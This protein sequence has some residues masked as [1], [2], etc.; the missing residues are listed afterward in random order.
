TTVAE[1]ALKRAPSVR[2]GQINEF[3]HPDWVARERL[4]NE[5]AG[6]RPATPLAEGFAKTALWYQERGLL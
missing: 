6:W 1:R 5:A 4:F 3:F 2:T